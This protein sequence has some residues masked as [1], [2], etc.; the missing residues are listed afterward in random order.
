MTK[1][2]AK[3]ETMRHRL[4]QLASEDAQAYLAVVAARSKDAR[5][6]RAAAARAAAVPKE[7]CRLCYKAV[8]LTPFLVAKGN[9]YLL[10]DVEVAIELL[11]ASFSSSVIMVRANT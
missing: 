10:S 1:L 7:I 9:P 11:M 4:L 8:E 2:L 6:Q 3:S 5:A